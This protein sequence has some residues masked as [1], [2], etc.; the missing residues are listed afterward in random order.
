VETRVVRHNTAVYQNQ[1]TTP[2]HLICTGH[3]VSVVSGF[4][5]LR[6]Y[7]CPCISPFVGLGLSSVRA[8]RSFA[9]CSTQ[10]RTLPRAHTHNRRESLSDYHS[11]CA[12]QEEQIVHTRR[13]S[14]GR[15]TCRPSS[16][17]P[18]CAPPTPP[19]SAILALA[20][21][22]VMIDDVCAVSGG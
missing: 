10:S 15:P 4:P 21:V 3:A 22:V 6:M 13:G 18:S 17:G 8:K 9:V 16:I 2:P 1:H 11:L 20:S 14:C 12:Y 5:P 7:A 19:T